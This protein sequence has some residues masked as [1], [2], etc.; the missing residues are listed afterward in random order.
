MQCDQGWGADCYRLWA[1][2]AAS[3]RVIAPHCKGV[4]NVM[5]PCSKSAEAL[6]T[7]EVPADVPHGAPKIH[8]KGLG[9]PTRS[10]MHLELGKS[11]KP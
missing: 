9:N 11:H 1:L 4:R 6:Q 8:V 10:A 2:H 7:L 5:Q 3:L